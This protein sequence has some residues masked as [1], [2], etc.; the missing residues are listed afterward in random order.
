[1]KT[2]AKLLG[3]GFGSYL[4]MLQIYEF[5]KKLATVSEQLFTLKECENKRESGVSN[6]LLLLLSLCMLRF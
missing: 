2:V 5:E 3:G 4:K 6:L 1:M